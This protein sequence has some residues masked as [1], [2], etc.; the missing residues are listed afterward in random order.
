MDRLENSLFNPIVL[1]QLFAEGVQQSVM[2]AQV[3]KAHHHK[4][5]HLRQSEKT[6]TC[7]HDKRTRT[8]PPQA[9]QTIEL[10]ITN[11]PATPVVR[12]LP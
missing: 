8:H 5:Q 12:A 4:Y 7:A 2:I 10:T 3:G 11:P 1:V 9:K 6:G